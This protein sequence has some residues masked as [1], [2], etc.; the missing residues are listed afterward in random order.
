MDLR[1]KR[2]GRFKTGPESIWP[3][4]TS[5]SR[6]PGGRHK[7]QSTRS[8]PYAIRS[9]SCARRPRIIFAICC[10]S[11]LSR[12]QISPIAKSY[13]AWSR[14]TSR[15]WYNVPKSILTAPLGRGLQIT[16]NEQKGVSDA[17]ALELTNLLLH[18]HERAAFVVLKSVGPDFITG[19]NNPRPPPGTP[20]ADALE[21]RRF[22][23]VIFNCYGAF[24]ACSVPIIGV[25]SGRAMG[26]GVS[27]AALCDITFAAD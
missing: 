13:A 11:T 22:S 7:K 12:T 25:V 23:E 9:A 19:R 8:A 18:A 16:L 26:L 21:R 5:R 24:R 2:Q 17:D 10:R 3:K 14:T 1:P 4:L 20:P 6:P 15:R 27:V